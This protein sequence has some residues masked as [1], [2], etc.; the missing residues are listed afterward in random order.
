MA[1]EWSR[2]GPNS[3]TS[4]RAAQDAGRR[5]RRPVEAAEQT[6]DTLQR[7]VAWTEET[8]DASN[9]ACGCVTE[10]AD[11]AARTAP[12]CRRHPRNHRFRS[13]ACA[14]VFA[15]G[16]SSS[17]PL[18]RDRTTTITTRR[19]DAAYQEQ[20]RTSTPGAH[21]PDPAPDMGVKRT[22]DELEREDSPEDTTTASAV[23]GGGYRPRRRGGGTG[24]NAGDLQRFRDGWD[25]WWPGGAGPRHRCRQVVASSTPAV[26]GAVGGRA[27]GWARCRWPGWEPGGRTSASQA[28]VPGGGRDLWHGRHSHTTRDRGG[29]A[30]RR[31]F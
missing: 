3:T 8:A 1:A 12:R 29:T 23:V 10:Q 6:R 4:A 26:S 17:R 15:L 30:S 19:G 18:E 5:R 31:P 16:P 28:A 2:W 24:L 9:R 25:A 11:L 13:P 20:S 27:T 7:L 14:P 21:V 22:P